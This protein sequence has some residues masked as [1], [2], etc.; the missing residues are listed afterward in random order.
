MS[1]L[2]F[3][4]ASVLI[5]A[6]AQF[7]FKGGLIDQPEIPESPSPFYRII[8]LVFRP[9]ILGGLLLSGVGAGLWLLALSDLELSY[10][11]PFLSL[12]Y[13]IIPI[14]AV[15]LYGERIGKVRKMGIGLICVGIL[16][17]AFS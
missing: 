4:I 16:F 12:N 9:K 11:F 10:A 1:A 5:M 15:V 3:A 7:L 8:D 13:I 2:I 17:I 14:G 6:S